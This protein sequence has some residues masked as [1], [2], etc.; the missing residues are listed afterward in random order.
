MAWTPDYKVIDLSQIA[1]NLL[2]YIDDNQTVALDWANDGPGLIE[3][4]K[5][6]TN[7]SGRLQT[8]FPSLMIL[9]QETG[10]DLEGDILQGGLKITLEATIAGPDTDELVA[11]TK[12][13]AKALESMLANIPSE[14]FTAGSDPVM[15]SALMEIETRLDVVRSIVGVSGFVQVFQ[16][17][18]LYKLLAAAF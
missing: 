9:T 2:G 11:N 16:I 10:T 7:S 6:Y 3:F 17:Q 8:I 12:L 15:H 14:T 4:A 5:F 1:D 13:Y 18:C